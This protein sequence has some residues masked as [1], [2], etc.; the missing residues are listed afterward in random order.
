MPECSCD[1]QCGEEESSEDWPG[2]LK[3]NI[4]TDRDVTREGQTGEQTV[5]ERE[6]AQ[7]CEG[8]CEKRK[9]MCLQPPCPLAA[10]FLT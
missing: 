9:H 10:S 5:R 8:K 4:Q 2:L 1:S 3:R 6:R 7:Q